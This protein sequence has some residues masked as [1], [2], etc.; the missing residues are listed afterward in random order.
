[1][2]R[3]L[4]YTPH[5]QSQSLDLLVSFRVASPK[6]VVLMVQH[7]LLFVTFLTAFGFGT[8]S[9][10][11]A[12]ETSAD[13]SI[14]AADN[15]VAWCIVPFDAKTRNP[16]ERA[17][18]LTRLGIKK[19]AYDWRQQHV[20]T[21]E[22]EILQYKRH[23]LEFFAFW[24]WHEDMVPL[25]KKHGIKPQIWM[26]NPSP[27]TGTQA[28]RVAGAAQQLLPLVRKA[29]QVGCKFG[30]YNH[31]GWGGEPANLVAVCKWL[32]ENAKADHVGIVYNFHHAHDQLDEYEELINVALPYLWS[33]NL[34]GMRKD[35]PKILTIGEGDREVERR[36]DL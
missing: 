14:F 2:A 12:D 9:V 32:H 5:G 36:I 27:G 20:P 25:I 30:L 18:M 21:F 19:V 26:T 13:R 3:E 11:D 24:S 10:C 33:V 23:N 17:E 4:R 1:M 15:L 7:L 8:A 31:G 29:E 22:E 16:A 34:N 6:V 35:G 28:E